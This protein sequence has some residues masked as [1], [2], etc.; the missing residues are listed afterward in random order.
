M[1][2]QEW[3]VLHRDYFIISAEI[4]TLGVSCHSSLLMISHAHPT[5]CNTV[6]TR[7]VFA[8]KMWPPFFVGYALLAG[9]VRRPQEAELV[10]EVL[11]KHFKRDVD[12]EQ[13]FSGIPCDVLPPEFSH[14]VWTRD[15]RRLAELLQRALRFEE[16]VLLVGETG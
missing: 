7:N 13:L 14:L 4:Y 6:G 15:A 5:N 3:A 9:R 8:P 1:P 16:P 2:L 11:A 12:P 10:A